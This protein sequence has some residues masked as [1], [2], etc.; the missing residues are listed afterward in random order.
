MPE[1]VKNAE[2]SFSKRLNI[3][4]SAVVIILAVSVLLLSLA[5]QS[6]LAKLQGLSLSSSSQQ[7]STT[8]FGSTLAGIDT[9]F[10]SS[11][12]SV[13][14]NAPNNYFEIAGERLL[15]GTLT[16]QVVFSKVPNSSKFN[17]FYINGKPSVIYIGA[18]SCIFCGEN[19]WA[20]ALALSR[21]GS[22][23]TLYT[24]Y[25][26]FGDGDVP[27]IYWTKDNYTTPAGVGYGNSY[28]SP[29]I[30]FISADYES[31]I[32]EGF[33]VQPLSYFVNNSPNATYRSALS[34]MNST[35]QFQGTPFTFWGNILVNGADAVVFG[36]TTPSSATL[37]LTY[38]THGQV[39]T[40]LKNFNDQFAW[41]EYAGADIYISYLCPT[42][43]NTAPVCSLPAIRA[44]EHAEGLA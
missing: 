14:N 3:V 29:Y 17:A 33:Q 8:G 43:N 34:F 44:I 41:S 37:P 24:G 42:I 28:S 39:L 23:S 38:M 13:I 5:Y 9:P 22:F 4:L 20:M 11:S 16:N 35:N 32:K 31:P 21:F 30:N 27:T 18:I 26:S 15:N 12:L 1:K 7:N 6:M 40:Q 2:L 36:N 19:R 25:S 10:N